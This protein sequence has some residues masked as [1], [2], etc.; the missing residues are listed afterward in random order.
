[1]VDELAAHAVHVRR[2]RP[3]STAAG[4][5]SDCRRARWTR[6]FIPDTREALDLRRR[7]LRHAAQLDELDRAPVAVGQALDDRP[8]AL[9][10]ERLV[11]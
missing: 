11:G 8:E 3:G 9:D 6:V 10:D 1:M 2:G 5:P 7:A 4:T